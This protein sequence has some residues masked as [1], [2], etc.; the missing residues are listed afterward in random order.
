MWPLGLR[1]Y[2]IRNV[3]N[4][5]SSANKHDSQTETDLNASIQLGT[6]EW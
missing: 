2:T 4:I 5:S 6:D 3:T 1:H